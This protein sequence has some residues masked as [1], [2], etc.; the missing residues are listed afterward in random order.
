MVVEAAA[1]AKIN[2]ASKNA[3]LLLAVLLAETAVGFL[4]PVLV[5]HATFAAQC[6]LAAHL[7]TALS[8]AESLEVEEVLQELREMHVL[9]VKHVLLLRKLK[10]AHAALSAE[11]KQRILCSP[12]GPLEVNS[13]SSFH[14]I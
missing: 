7:A 1:V 10:A 8:L 3:A 2:V 11:N 14:H 13:F 5:E 4:A 9:H 6:K 12:R